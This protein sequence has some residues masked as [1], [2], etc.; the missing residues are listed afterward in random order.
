MTDQDKLNLIKEKLE[1]LRADPIL[2]MSKLITVVNRQKEVV[3]LNLYPGQLKYIQ[4][5]RTVN[6]VIKPRRVGLTV[7][8]MAEDVLN[9]RFYKNFHSL[10]LNKDAADNSALFNIAKGMDD[11]LHPYLKGEK[12]R[13]TTTILWYKDTNSSLSIQTVGMTPEQASKKGRG[14]ELSDIHGTEVGYWKP[15]Q[16]SEVIHGAGN[17]RTFDSRMTFESTSSGPR[18]DFSRACMEMYLNGKEDSDGVWYDGDRALIFLSWLQHPEYYLPLEGNETI[19]DEDD[20]EERLF[21]LGAKPEQIKWRRKKLNQSKSEVISGSKYTPEQRFKQ[22]FP[23]TFM[24]AMEESQG[25][26]FERKTMVAVKSWGEQTQDSPVTCGLTTGPNAD[27]VVMPPDSRNRYTM[28]LPPAKGWQN[29][30]IVFVDC[31]TGDVNSDF[32]VGY[33]YDL[34][35]NMVVCAYWGKYGNATSCAMALSMCKYYNNA[36]LGWDRGGVG[37]GFS[38]N[39]VMYGYPYIWH[40]G[41]HEQEKQ[42]ETT[43]G[44]HWTPRAKNFAL[45]MLRAGI[46][47]RFHMNLCGEFY[48]ETEF[49]GWQDPDDVCPT[50]PSGSHDDHIMC[51]AGIELMKHDL[52]LQPKQIEVNHPTK[53]VHMFDVGKIVR[54]LNKRDKM[55]RKRKDMWS[56]YGN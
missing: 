24:D 8:K 28:W 20:E 38:A 32:D 36:I 7:V 13:D 33:C 34:V 31:A 18:G 2:A 48:K 55:T 45:E 3:P 30:Y 37:D 14:N 10:I 12:N 26:F 47:E 11:R 21:K 29:R 56:I 50:A 54:D 40:Y 6:Y 43:M 22:E 15:G 42:R 52:K 44:V 16:L 17:T 27:V 46:Y 39:V 23:A 19:T 35:S 1:K 41:V 5:R 53:S 25:L 4:K 51:A 9:A 49:F